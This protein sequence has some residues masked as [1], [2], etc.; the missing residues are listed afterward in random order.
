M[1][2]SVDC[3][4]HSSVLVSITHQL[5]TETNLAQAICTLPTISKVFHSS[6][7]LEN[8][9]VELHIKYSMKFPFLFCCSMN[10]IAVLNHGLVRSVQDIASSVYMFTTST[11]F[12]FAQFL[13]SVI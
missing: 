13:Q 3:I 10:L 12:L 7:D 2:L 5:P 9:E 8:L 4:S 6:G 1:K 11:S